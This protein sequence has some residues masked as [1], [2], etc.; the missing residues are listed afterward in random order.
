MIFLRDEDDDS[1]NW[2]ELDPGSLRVDI[3]EEIPLPKALRRLR[4]GEGGGVR[5]RSGTIL[6]ARVSLSLFFSGSDALSQFHA[7]R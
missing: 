1:R 6:F 3:L 5:R 7:Q 2:R 4:E